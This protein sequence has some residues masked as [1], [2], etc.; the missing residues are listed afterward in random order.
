MKVRL[1]NGSLIQVIGTDHIDGIV[2]TNPVGCVFTE[3]S[4]QDPKAWT[5]IRPILRENGGWAIFNFTPR[6]ANH[7]KELYDMACGNSDWFCQL[8]T[9]DDTGVLN[10][11]DIQKERD[12][13]MSEDFIQQEY[14]CSFTLGVEGSYYARYLEEARD[15]DR[16]GRVPLDPQKRVYTAWDLG[17]GDST[18]I[19]F[20]QLC[21]QE[22]HIIDYYEAHGEGLPHYATVLKDKGYLY[23]EHYAPHDIDSHAFS[24]G[25]SA[26]EVGASLGIKFITLPTLKLRLEDGIEAVRS[27][28]PR[29][30]FDEKKSASLIK[31]LENYRKEFD[32]NMGTYRNRPRHDKY[33][34]GCFVGST[35]I[36]VESDGEKPIK[37]ILVDDFVVTPNGLRRVVKTFQYDVNELITVICNGHSF[38]CTPNHK[39]FTKR[40]LI[41]AD[42][43]MYNDIL[44]TESDLY[45]CKK[46]FGLNSSILSTG[47]RENFLLAQTKVGLFST[48]INSDGTVVTIEE[49]LQKTLQTPHYKGAFGHIIM[50]RFLK[51]CTSIIKTAM[52]KIIALKISKLSPTPIIADCTCVCRKEENVPAYPYTKS[53]D[54][55][56]NGIPA[57]LVLNGIKNM[58]KTSDLVIFKSL[59]YVGN[60][61]KN[62]WQRHIIRSSVPQPAKQRI[63]HCPKSTTTCANAA[64]AK[65]N[66][67]VTDMLP[68]G[69]VLKIVRQSYPATQK[70]YDFEVEKDHCYY[71]NG[72]LVTNSDAFRYLA[73]AVKIYVDAGKAGVDDK[74]SDKWYDQFHPRF[75]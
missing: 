18:A 6:G 24:S 34:H 22:I 17:Y 51:K 46:K 2:G 58:L 62:I 52:Q 67:N 9:V 31:C 73:I 50:D 29:L 25:L 72:V 64:Y 41:F 54:L 27:L 57:S 59:R 65:C 1:K 48:D 7:G 56:N 45:E 44:Y 43:L 60:V 19:V 21:G 10:D 15:D 53:W 8:L 75:D 33:S 66:L 63:V 61:T 23:A 74:Q 26:R 30:W 68:K 4:L 70:V 13:G 39:I 35:L 28:F 16:V 32:D 3:Y 12:E 37:H 71:A 14:F 49:E 42:D 36:S 40:G 20:Y 38:Q 69:L 5:L 55:L 47:F 11:S